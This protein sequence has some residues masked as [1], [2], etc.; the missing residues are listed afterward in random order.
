[1]DPGDRGR[2]LGPQS[3]SGLRVVTFGC[4]RDASIVPTCG[5]SRAYPC[6]LL[7]PQLI[8]MF[9]DIQRYTFRDSRT[10]HEAGFPG[11]PTQLRPLEAAINVRW[12][13]HAS[14][15][16]DRV[17]TVSPFPCRGYPVLVPDS[18]ENRDMGPRSS[19]VLRQHATSRNEFHYLS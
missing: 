10:R 19:V 3:A 12:R 9:T 13:L 18:R 1:V 14:K 8:Q 5:Q 4:E 7:T 2:Q 16:P 17:G 6:L 11:P 15:G